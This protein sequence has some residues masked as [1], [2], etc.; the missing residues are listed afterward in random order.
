MVLHL[1]TGF[2]LEDELWCVADWARLGTVRTITTLNLFTHSQFI[3]H[4]PRL[5]C[6]LP[7]HLLGVMSPPSNPCCARVQRPYSP[8][9]SFIAQRNNKK[10]CHHKTLSHLLLLTLSPIPYGTLHAQSCSSHA[11]YLK[12]VA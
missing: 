8:S 10:V 3:S 6:R 9:F 12:L 7:T 1:V 11:P 5:S 4:A 2:E